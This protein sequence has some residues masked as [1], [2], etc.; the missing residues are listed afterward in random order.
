[1]ERYEVKI[2]DIFRLMW[3]YDQTNNN[4]YQVISLA[5]KTGVRVK[6][7][8]PKITKLLDQGDMH[9]T[10]EIENNGSMQDVIENGFYIK[11][12][13]DGDIKYPKDI[14][15]DICIKIGDHWAKLYK[16]GKIYESYWA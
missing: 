8:S 14:Y 7:V 11:N 13:K 12:K 5:G 3:G 6:E 16:G 2:G 10:Y 4:F 15:G 9:K 1:M